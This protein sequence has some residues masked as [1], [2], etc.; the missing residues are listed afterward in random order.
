MTVNEMITK[1]THIAELGGGEFDVKVWQLDD[2]YAA[3]ETSVE[4]VAGSFI[5]AGSD[6]DKAIIFLKK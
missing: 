1:L 2:D 3:T 5:E 6:E 4:M